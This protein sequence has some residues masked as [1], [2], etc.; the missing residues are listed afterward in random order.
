MCGLAPFQKFRW[1]RQVGSLAGQPTHQPCDG[2]REGSTS[3]C[4]VIRSIRGR[5]SE[6]RVRRAGGAGMKAR[7]AS[8]PLHGGLT[9]LHGDAGRRP[10]VG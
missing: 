10:E 5:L 8:L 4:P 6:G 7:P 1:T 9:S 2:S 3:Y